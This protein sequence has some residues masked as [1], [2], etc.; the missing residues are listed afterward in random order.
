[1]AAALTMVSGVAVA[2]GVISAGVIAADLV[3]GRHQKMRIMNAV[4]PLTA[5]WAG[6]LGLGAYFRFGRAPRTHDPPDAGQPP[7]FVVAVGKATTH[8]GSGCTLGDLLAESFAALAPLTV[9]GQRL[10]GSW[11][12]DFVAA[13]VLGIVFQYFTIKPMSDLSRGQALVRAVKADTLSLLA[14]QTGMYGWMAIARFVIFERDLPKTSPIF[15]FMMQLGM[16]LGFAT[17]YPVNWWLLR[18]GIK[19]PM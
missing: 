14:W 1:V 4:W 9:F 7:S 6:P 15:W 16:L 18:R 8:C 5:L 11:A 3:A 19:D 17:S 10:F 2:A 13:Y 12:Y